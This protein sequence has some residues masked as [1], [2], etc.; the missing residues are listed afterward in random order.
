MP[1]LKVTKGRRRSLLPS[2]HNRWLVIIASD[3]SLSSPLLVSTS[4]NESVTTLL[5]ICIG[6][7]LFF[8]SSVL[9]HQLDL[10]FSSSSPRAAST[11][12]TITNADTINT[13][14][15]HLLPPFLLPI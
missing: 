4:L 14:F 11:D 10:F 15:I 6:L 7:L 1:T 3:L 8:N 2:D 13:T 9:L 12:T 5:C